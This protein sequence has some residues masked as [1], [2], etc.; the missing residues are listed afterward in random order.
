MARSAPIRPTYDWTPDR[1]ARL[2]TLYADQF[3]WEEVGRELGVGRS[4][5]YHRGRALGIPMRP[6]GRLPRMGYSDTAFDKISRSVDGRPAAFAHFVCKGCGAVLDLPM[7]GHGSMPPEGYAKRAVAKGWLAHPTKRARI[8]CQTCATARPNNDPDS[9][10][11]KMSVTPLPT[12]IPPTREITADERLRIRNALDKNF[13]DGVGCYLDD[14][15]DDRIATQLGVPRV[16]VERMR[17]AAYGPIRVDPVLAGLRAELAQSKRELDA[18]KA[19]LS[20][21][22][23]VLMGLSSRVERKMAGKS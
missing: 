4:A 5:A 23:S 17:E 3:T 7:E 2:A 14:M 18:A 21:L 12:S 8:F 1:D 22:E 11:K 9:E 16:F 10:L 20:K 19:T 6:K 15:S 13:D